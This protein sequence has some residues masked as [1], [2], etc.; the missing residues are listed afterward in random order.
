MAV[1]IVDVVPSMNV[2]PIFVSSIGAS[3]TAV[4][5]IVTVPKAG[6]APSSPPSANE[7]LKPEVTVS[8]PSWTKITLLLFTSSCVKEVIATPGL[9]PS[10]I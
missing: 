1:V 9:V 7:T 10:S 5:P 6:V 8:E 2:A 4:M 3:S